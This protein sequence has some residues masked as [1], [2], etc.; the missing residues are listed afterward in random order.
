MENYYI[1]THVHF[2]DPRLYNNLETLIEKAYKSNVKKMIVVG[3]NVISSEVAIDIAKARKNIYST[4]GI[5]PH[6]AKDFKE[7][8][9]E[10][11]KELLK[12]ENITAIGE[13]GL[14][15]Y[16]KIS[17]MPKQIK[18][19]IKQI[20][21]AIDNNLPIIIHSRN[22]IDKVLDIIDQYNY[23]KFLLH[24]FEGNQ[25]H[26]EKCLKKGYF[27]SFNGILTF[28]KSDRKELLKI[29]GLNNILIETDSP[30]LAPVPKRGKPNDPSNIPYISLFIAE[31]LNIKNET[32]MEKLLN[33][34]I[35]F[36]NINKSLD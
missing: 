33:N 13:I 23:S 12:K 20:E 18:I 30:Y 27:I 5:H 35:T 3:Y 6:Y 28:K 2:Q 10:Y 26:L 31:E 9:I 1:D 25:Y 24:S 29:T 15:N 14:D 32:V 4:I 34:S 11:F 19:F 7:E 22:S 21:L 17:D 36:F 8:N 16:Y